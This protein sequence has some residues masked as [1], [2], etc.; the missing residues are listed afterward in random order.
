MVAA[1]AEDFSSKTCE[2]PNAAARAAALN[3][4]GPAPT[5]AI[6]YFLVTFVSHLLLQACQSKMNN[7]VIFSFLA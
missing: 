6:S 4:P 5:T 1:I 3:P 7:I 2:M